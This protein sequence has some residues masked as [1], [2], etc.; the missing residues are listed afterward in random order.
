MSRYFLPI[1][2]ATAVLAKTDLVGCTSLTYTYP[3]SSGDSIKTIIH[4]VPETHE[5][6]IPIDCGGTDPA[7]G[8]RVP[9][10][11]GYSGT[12]IITKSFLSSC[13]TVKPPTVTVTQTLATPGSNSGVGSTTV[14]VTPPTTTST[15]IKTVTTSLISPLSSLTPSGITT[16]TGGA[17]STLITSTEGEVVP[18]ETGSGAEP[19][20]STVP[21]GAG[22]TARAGMAAVLGVAAAVVAFA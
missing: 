6:C 5:I 21:A 7:S 20:S 14:T 4:Y 1:L 8:K 18:T 13:A 17:G 16:R 2:A 12:E 3:G 19:S 22:S 9:G 10:C 15:V 11:P